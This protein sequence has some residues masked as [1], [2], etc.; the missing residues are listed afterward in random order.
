MSDNP[1]PPA[2][3]Y[4]DPEYPGQLRYWDATAWTDQRRPVTAPPPPGP[5]SS[6]PPSPY[7]PAAGDRTNAGIALALSILGLVLCG[8]LAPVG[9]VMGRSELQRIDAGQGDP[10]ARGM[11]QAAWIIGLIGTI[12]LIVGVLLLL[13]FLTVVAS[14][15]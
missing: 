7:P 9:M 11:A 5:G 15:T 4:P 1:T 13:F 2:G 10:N 12:I 8:V 3:W 14:G 6:P